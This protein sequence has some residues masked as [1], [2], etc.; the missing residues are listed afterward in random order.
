MQETERLRQAIE[1]AIDKICPDPE[2]GGKLALPITSRRARKRTYP[3][4]KCGKFWQ[5]TIETEWVEVDD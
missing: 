3:C 2:C 4:P 5:L 1:E